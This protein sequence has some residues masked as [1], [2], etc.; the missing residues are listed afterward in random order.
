M[1]D[2]DEFLGRGI[3]AARSGRSAEA[4]KYLE[5]AVKMDPAN[6]RIWLWMATGVRTYAEKQYCLETVLKLDPSSTVAKV[7]LE[8]LQQKISAE[9]LRPKDVVI[10]TCSSCGGKQRFDPD[11][12][13]LVCEFCRR[14]EPLLLADASNAE[15]SLDDGLAHSSGN[16]A[17]IESQISCKACGANLFVPADRSTMTCPPR[18]P[19]S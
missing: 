11:L 17:V 9:N 13:G 15:V 12:I 19:N 5:I 18:L 1:Y 7:L 8:R 2:V 4:I 16:W 6:P 10:F 3:I 14:V